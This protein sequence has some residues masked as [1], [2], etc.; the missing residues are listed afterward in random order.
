VVQVLNRLKGRDGDIMPYAAANTLVVT[1]L[2]SNIRRMEEVVRALDQPM[3]GE[4]IWVV[5]LKNIV[6][7]EVLQMLQQVFGVGK[8]L[9]TG[10]AATRA[11]IQVGSVGMESASAVDRL[12]AATTR[13]ARSLPMTA[14]TRS[15]W[16]RR[17]GPTSGCL[18]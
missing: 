10:A 18:R 8:H 5:R 14:P 1:D 9:G 11:P 12:A 17:S 6:A 16:C 13:S 4:K 7:T 2:A 15:S 3:A